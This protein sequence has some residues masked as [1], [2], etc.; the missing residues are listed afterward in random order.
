MKGEEVKQSELESQLEINTLHLLPVVLLHPLKVKQLLVA[1][2]TLAGEMPIRIRAQQFSPTPIA[3]VL[4]A[5]PASHL[6]LANH[7]PIVQ[8]T[9]GIT[10]VITPRRLFRVHSASWASH[11]RLFQPL[12]VRPVFFELPC[13]PLQVPLAESALQRDPLLRSFPQSHVLEYKPLGRCKG[14]ISMR[15]VPLCQAFNISMPAPQHIYGGRRT[16]FSGNTHRRNN[17]RPCTSAISPIRC[18]SPP[19][20][21]SLPDAGRNPWGT[22]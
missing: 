5:F 3:K 14:A 8:Q 13:Q 16:M 2:V 4:R 20:P 15:P 1:R 11:R 7:K 19:A 12:P 10:Y 17:R 6:P 18:H 9:K 21:A 22:E